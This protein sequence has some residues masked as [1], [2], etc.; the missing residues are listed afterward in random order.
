MNES[1][2]AA[3][4]CRLRILAAEKMKG[5]LNGII[6]AYYCYP[7]SG[8]GPASLALQPSM[9]LQAQRAIGIDAYDNPDNASAG[10]PSPRLLK[11]SIAS[12]VKAA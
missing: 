1:F 10:I 5:T 2:E 6:T 3:I 8:R 12:V 4:F 9:G 7:A 11:Q